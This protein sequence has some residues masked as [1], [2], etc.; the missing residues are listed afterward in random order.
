MSKIKVKV[1][2]N[3]FLSLSSTNL[4]IF[5]LNLTQFGNFQNNFHILNSK[6]VNY[7]RNSEKF[8]GAVLPYSR[9]FS[10]LLKEDKGV[11]LLKF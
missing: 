4:T 3:D 7:F 5:Y 1:V 6:L 8:L 2:T 10:C 9:V 11:V